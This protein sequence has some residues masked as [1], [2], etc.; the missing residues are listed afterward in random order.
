MILVLIAGMLYMAVG[1][2]VSIISCFLK[3]KGICLTIAFTLYIAGILNVI[4]YHATEAPSA[5]SV[6]AM[7]PCTRSFIIIPLPPNQN[8]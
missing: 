6:S 5:V 4:I 7:Q 2:L 3:Q 1:I 8:L